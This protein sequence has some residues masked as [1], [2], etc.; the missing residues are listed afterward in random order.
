MAAVLV[1]TS[2]DLIMKP[3]ISMIPLGVRDLEK[4]NDFYGN[5]L[6]IPRMESPPTVAFFT[7]NGTWLGL[8]GRDV[9]AE[10]ATVPAEDSG[11]N[12]FAL[13]HNLE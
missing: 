3:R 13:A 12:S 9:L 8:Y 2:K 7:L 1:Q 5:G 4:S 6:G 10:D 11:F